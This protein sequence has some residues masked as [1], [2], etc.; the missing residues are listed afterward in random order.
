MAA[1]AF[2]SGNSA[3]HGLGGCSVVIFYLVICIVV[4]RVEVVRDREVSLKL[5]MNEGASWSRSPKR[6]PELETQHLGLIQI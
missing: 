2:G 4:C 5:L 6:L 3:C 1:S